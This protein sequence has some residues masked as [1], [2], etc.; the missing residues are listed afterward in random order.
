MCKKARKT[1]SQ[2]A[3]LFLYC[4]GIRC[5]GNKMSPLLA[6]SVNIIFRA[7]AKCTVEAFLGMLKETVFRGGIKVKTCTM[8]LLKRALLGAG[9][10]SSPEDILAPTWEIHLRYTQ[11]DR[12]KL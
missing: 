12:E 8:E 6:G 3:E 9:G 1:I 4:L 10:C 11:I 5:L 2:N 7:A